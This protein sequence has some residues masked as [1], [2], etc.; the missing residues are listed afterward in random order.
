MKPTEEIEILDAMVTERDDLIFALHTGAELT[1][2]QT[3]I[4]RNIVAD[5]HGYGF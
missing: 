3:Q 2:A 1:M 4:L 5:H